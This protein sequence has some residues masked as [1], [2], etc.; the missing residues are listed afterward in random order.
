MLKNPKRSTSLSEG[1]VLVGLPL[2]LDGR[3][4]LGKVERGRRGFFTLGARI[5]ALY[6]P[7]LGGWSLPEGNA[8]GGPSGGSRVSTPPW[9]LASAAGARSATE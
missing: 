1:G 7:S 6:G 2:A 5:G 8:T 3:V 9:R 4:P